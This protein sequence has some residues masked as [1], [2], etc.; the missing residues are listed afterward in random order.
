MINFIF[1]LGI[2]SFPCVVPYVL[3]SRLMEL[4]QQKRAE[5]MRKA[6]MAHRSSVECQARQ[7]LQEKDNATDLRHIDK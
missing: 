7:R 6:Y 2:F 3:S 4:I 1:I 5:A